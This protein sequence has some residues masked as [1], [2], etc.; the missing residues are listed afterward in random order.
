MDWKVN[1][2]L[3]ATIFSNADG[4]NRSQILILDKDMLLASNISIEE[5]P[6]ESAAI[7]EVNECHRDLSLLDY[8]AMG[9]IAGTL[10]HIIS[11]YSSLP[12]K[13]ARNYAYYKQF[14]EK[15][16][17]NIV[18]NAIKEGKIDPYKIK[19]ERWKEKLSGLFD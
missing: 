15:E 12:A 8:N 13:E 18:E 14:T 9:T 5:N 1:S 7:D 16:T 10:A 6:G 4:P 11:E 19:S 2:T 3:L 17:K